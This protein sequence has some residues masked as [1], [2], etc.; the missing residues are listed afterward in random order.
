MP[1]QGGETFTKS[2]RIHPAS[3]NSCFL[4]SGKLGMFLS[5]LPGHLPGMMITEC[6]AAT[7]T[8]PGWILA[9]QEQRVG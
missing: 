4:P 1:H 5:S 9:P 7:E 2:Y 8:S 3:H 6:P